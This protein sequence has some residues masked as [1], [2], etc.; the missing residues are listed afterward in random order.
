[1]PV[2]IRVLSTTAM[3]SSLD[4][5]VPRF[6]QDTGHSVVFTYTPS[7]QILRRSVD[8]DRS[9][10]VIA[11]AEVIAE[12]I[13]HGKI[14][15]GSDAALARSQI[16]LAVQRGAPLPDISS[17]EKFKTALLEARAIGMSNPVGGGQS[18]RY[19]VEIFERLGI[20][21]AVKAKVV[22]GPGG[23]AGLIGHFLARGDVDVGLQQ[24]AELRAVPDIQVVG[25]LPPD[26]QRETVFSAGLSHA[27]VQPDSGTTLIRALR[28]RAAAAIIAAK[29]FTAAHAG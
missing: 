20:A 18:G 5:I 19:L 22:Y 25:P 9:D 26:I 16:G 15:A 10:V 17:A 13:D 2:Q 8:G 6:E 12:L 14:V 29:G 28:G 21:D 7:A 4:S 24:M 3:K 23:P 1:M 11:T 27:A